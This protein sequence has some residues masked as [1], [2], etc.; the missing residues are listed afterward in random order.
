M[1]DLLLNDW[2]TPFDS[3]MLGYNVSFLFLFVFKKLGHYIAA[4]SGGGGGREED[5]ES[6]VA[7]GH[8]SEA[9]PHPAPRGYW[10]AVRDTTFHCEYFTLTADQSCGSGSAGIVTIFLDPHPGPAD[11]DPPPF[12]PKEEKVKPYQ[13]WGSG[14]A[15]SA[16]FWVFRIRILVKGTDP[17]P[18]PS[19]FS[20]RCWWDWNNACKIKF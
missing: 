11:P 1:A 19:L 12:Q 17:D 5:V 20:Y 3:T 14:S 10:D 9:G 6:A 18:D 4:A 13:C 16:W 8:P 7:H 2:V 15:G